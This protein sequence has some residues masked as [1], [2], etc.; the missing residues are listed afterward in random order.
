[1]RWFFSLSVRMYELNSSN[2]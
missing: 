1:M 2:F